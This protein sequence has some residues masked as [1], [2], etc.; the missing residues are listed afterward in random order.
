MKKQTIAFLFNVRHI[1]PNPDDLATQLETDFDDP[2]TITMM[3][4]HLESAGFRVI[5]IEANEEA[6]IKLTH[7][8][9]E[10]DLVFNYSEGMYG[11]DREAQLPAMLE[12]LQIPYTGSS[13]LTQSLVLNKVKTKEILLA[14]HIP[15]APY[16]LFKTGKEKL[17]STLSFPLMVKPLSQGSS[18]G[19]TNDSLVESSKKL[20]Q[21]VRCIRE[22]FNQP[23]L[24]EHY[25]A[26]REFSIA[27]LGNPPRLL[28]PIEP[29]HTTLPTGYHPIDSLEV[30]WIFEEQNNQNYLHCPAHVD[31]KL[32][33][34]LETMCYQTWQA[35][36]ISDFCRIDIRCDQHNNPYVLEVNSPPGL[37]PPEVSQTSYFPLAARAAGFD[38]QTLLK[39]IIHSAQE[40]YKTVS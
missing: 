3:Q 21:Q 17:L 35:L 7:Y 22:T 38:Y 6:Y 16:Q 19:I 25:L 14:N 39:T 12:M 8:K 33:K 23:A 9:K 30:K 1:Y 37:L 28:P 11:K 5:P 4:Y 40:R 20:Y 32:W 15:T 26:G 29:A 34:K 13:P 10:I 27:M 24:V 31:K 36:E 2:K 18:A